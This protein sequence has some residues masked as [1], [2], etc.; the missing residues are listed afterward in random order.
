M[1]TQSVAFCQGVDELSDI[2]DDTNLTLPS[3]ETVT[4]LKY[5]LALHTMVA[6]RELTKD[7]SSSYTCDRHTFGET[8]FPVTIPQH[9]KCIQ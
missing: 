9:S 8:L 2:S 5:L 6:S 1:C 3:S 4:S 7:L